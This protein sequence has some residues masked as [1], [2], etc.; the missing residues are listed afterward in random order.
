MIRAQH[1]ALA[2]ASSA[3][4]I[5]WS[6]PTCAETLAEA[7]AA[8]TLPTSGAAESTLES[9]FHQADEQFQAANYARAAELFTRVWQL[10]QTPEHRDRWGR[11][12]AIFAFNA[13]TSHR[14]EGNCEAAVT[15]FARYVSEFEVLPPEQQQTLREAT[16]LPADN[17]T[18][19]AEL[20]EECPNTSSVGNTSPAPSSAAQP[21]HAA[22]DWLLDV[23]VP[24]PKPT[25]PKDSP[26]AS[27]SRLGWFLTAGGVASL[28]VSGYFLS[29]GIGNNQDAT[30]PAKKH[31]RYVDYEAERDSDY[32]IAGVVGGIGIGLASV[33]LY[34][35][36]SSDEDAGGKSRD[37]KQTASGSRVWL[38]AS[39]DRVG[40][41][42]SL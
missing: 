40:F 32:L 33:G 27:S 24:K 11:Y 34:L 7:G 8:Q 35:L 2:F 12:T 23:N 30:N 21:R 22:S 15:T 31:E 6:P 17:G 42:G 5:V 41:A 16:D 1:L 13:A 14:L 38:F 18:W 26:D 36:L 20:K 37:G 39:G 3:W 19:L 29:S 9:T 4:S 28:A 10:A 25:V